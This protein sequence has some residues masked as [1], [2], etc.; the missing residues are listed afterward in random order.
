MLTGGC[1]CGGV[2]FEVT[3]P[4]AVA[5]YCHCTRC[6]RRT[7]SAAAVS[8]LLAPGS[9]KV[10]SGEDLLGAYDPGDGGFLKVFCTSC[11]SALWSR[12]P[13]EDVVGV[14]MGA[15]DSDPGVRPSYRQFVASAA[16][17]EPIPDDGLPRFDGRRTSS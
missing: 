8:A 17:W 10:L 1:L 3:E 15:F 9:L 11:G 4:P 13:S 7:G 6:Q 14:R 12:H 16:P 2:T 5:G